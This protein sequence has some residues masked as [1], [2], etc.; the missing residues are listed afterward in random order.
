MAYIIITNNIKVKEKYE[1]TYFIDGLSKDVLIKVR[2]LI[3]QGYE[4]IS[5]PLPA[6]I[7]IMSSPFRSIVITKEKKPTID[8]LQWEVIENSIMKLRRYIKLNGIDS[9]HEDDYKKLDYLFLESALEEF[10]NLIC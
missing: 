6:S 10:N 2:D 9:R 3:H 1:E 8:P 4:L 7:K 5:H